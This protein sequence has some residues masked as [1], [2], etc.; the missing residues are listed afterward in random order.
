[1]TTPTPTEP[2]QEQK[3]AYRKW[4]KGP[5][6]YGADALRDFVLSCLPPAIP[7]AGQGGSYPEIQDNSPAPPTQASKGNGIVI[8]NDDWR[9]TAK[10]RN[11]GGATFNIGSRFVGHEINITAADLARLVA[12]AS[13]PPGVVKD[14]LACSVLV[15]N[16]PDGEVRVP[17]APS[18]PVGKVVIDLEVA[19]RLLQYADTYGTGLKDAASKDADALSA[20]IAEAETIE[21]T[22]P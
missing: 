16:T 14:L 19:K 17:P 6:L 13:P 7:E 20:A 5:G 21:R 9:L 3:D 15:R 8:G 12:A 1:M 2:T 22:K 4:W 18:P 11:D 10:W